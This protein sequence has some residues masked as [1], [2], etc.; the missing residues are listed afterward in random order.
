MTAG[1]KK[2]RN[3]TEEKTIGADGSAPPAPS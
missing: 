1:R 2:K 3:V